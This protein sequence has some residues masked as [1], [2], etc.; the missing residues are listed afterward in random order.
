MAFFKSP[1]DM[2]TA[3]AK[4]FKAQ[5]DAHWAMPTMK[6]MRKGAVIPARHS[7]KAKRK[8]ERK[9]LHAFWLCAAALLF[10]LVSFSSL[11]I[12]FSSPTGYTDAI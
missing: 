12:D 9:L 8:S 7:P 1:E 5:G 6:P 11:L 10:P 3:R 4:S 2:Y